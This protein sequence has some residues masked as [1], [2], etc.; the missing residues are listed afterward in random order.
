MVGLPIIVTRAEYMVVP[1]EEEV[2]LEDYLQ[3]LMHKLHTM[4]LEYREANPLPLITK[5][6][7]KGEEVD[8]AAQETRN[9]K[10]IDLKY[11][12]YMR[13]YGEKYE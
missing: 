2:N 11:L 10:F 7:L 9:F 12:P 4:R 13:I 8:P 5:G 3:I 6:R 1:N